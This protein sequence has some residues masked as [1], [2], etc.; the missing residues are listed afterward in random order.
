ME[1]KLGDKYFFKLVDGGCYNG[2]IVKIDDSM[3]F[4]FINILDKF[5][6]PVGFREDKIE[7][8]ELLTKNKV[9]KSM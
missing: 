4:K 3:G 1:W 2:K 8:Y 7:K 5:D 6:N 9:N